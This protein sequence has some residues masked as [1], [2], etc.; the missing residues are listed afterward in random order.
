MLTYWGKDKNRKKYFNGSRAGLQNFIFQ[1]NQS[2][3][4]HLMAF[5]AIFLVT[6]LLLYKSLFI[7]AFI[8]TV[9]NIIGNLYPVI[10]QRYH[11]VRTDLI[12]Q[13]L[14]TRPA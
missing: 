11:R 9:I 5:S 8:T 7:A 6:L 4:G 1:A 3:F 2:E 12:L 14:R 13:K 10:L